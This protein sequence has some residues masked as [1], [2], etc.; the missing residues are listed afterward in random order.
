MLSLNLNYSFRELHGS[1]PS[2][3]NNNKSNKK[4]SITDMQGM[5]WTKLI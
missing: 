4:L 5:D 1:Q 2:H 3:N